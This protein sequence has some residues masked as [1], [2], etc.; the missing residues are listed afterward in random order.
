MKIVVAVDDVWACEP[1]MR[2]AR[3][4]VRASPQDRVTVTR[5]PGPSPL[6]RLA[7]RARLEWAAIRDGAAAAGTPA[8]DRNADLIVMAAASLAA[9]GARAHWRLA[10]DAEADVLAVRSGFPLGAAIIALDG[11]PASLHG[12]QSFAT[13]VRTAGVRV[14]LIHVL[15]G[16]PAHH[17]TAGDLPSTMPNLEAGHD[18]AAIFD[19]ALRLLAAHGIPADTE[20]RSGDAAAEIAKVAERHGAGLVVMGSRGLAALPSVLFG[21]V[22]RGVLRA[23]SASV[24]ISKGRKR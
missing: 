6:V 15:D 11:S 10:R 18:A 13:K 24:L 2:A 20:L 8:A 9:S 7:P 16:T 19:P 23:A 5:L 4:Y 21:S 22:T 1:L 14:R 3:E 12:V 17:P